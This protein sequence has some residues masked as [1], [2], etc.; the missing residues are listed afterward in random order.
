MSLL[1]LVFEVTDVPLTY[2]IVNNDE[3]EAL[4]VGL[5]II[6][7]SHSEDRIFIRPILLFDAIFAHGS[8]F[9]ILSKIVKRWYYFG[10]NDR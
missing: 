1:L 8:P 4:R 5:I 2:G 9:P 10:L 6:P 3:S 7:Y